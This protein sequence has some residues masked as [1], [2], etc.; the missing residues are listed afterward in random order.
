MCVCAKIHIFF[1]Y[2]T[3]CAWILGPD[4]SMWLIT[5]LGVSGF[6]DLAV[7]CDGSSMWLITEPGRIL[8]RPTDGI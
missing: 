8:S 5:E 7:R 4:R 3:G 1:D 2:G 6:W